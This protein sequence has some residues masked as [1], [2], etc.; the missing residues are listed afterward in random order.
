MGTFQIEAVPSVQEPK[1]RDQQIL[2]PV[3][4]S[5]WRATRGRR[6]FQS[7]PSEQ[8]I[9]APTLESEWLAPREF[10]RDDKSDP[11]PDQIKRV[12]EP[13]VSAVSAP[14]APILTKRFSFSGRSVA[15]ST[16]LALIA[17]IGVGAGWAW[18]SPHISRTAAPEQIF[19]SEF[20]TQL[21]VI[22]QDLSSLRQDL[23][24]LAARQEEI[25]GAQ[26]RLG[27][28]QA[29][30][31]AVQEQGTVKQEQMLQAISK[32]RT[33]EPLTRPASPERRARTGAPSRGYRLFP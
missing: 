2:T 30:L 33:V 31:A 15:T 8:R 22:T 10:I 4:E 1:S 16:V 27:A 5:E 25:A 7:V 32:L 9:S 17:G 6:A 28:T 20:I 23:K 14:E 19:S 21:N 3:S 12:T 11:A 29:H 26:E 24:T 13:D 18:I